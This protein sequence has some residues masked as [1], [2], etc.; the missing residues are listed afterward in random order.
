MG[1]KSPNLFGLVPPMCSW[2]PI[3]VFW[4]DKRDSSEIRKSAISLQQND[5]ETC[6]I[7]LWTAFCMTLKVAASK[8]KI[9]KFFMIKCSRTCWSYER[10]KVALPPPEN[11]GTKRFWKSLIIGKTIRKIWSGMFFCFEKNP[12]SVFFF[13]IRSSFINKNGLKSKK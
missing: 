9:S 7:W 13:R 12:L 10:A 11:I 2:R 3:E 5:L 4:P 6:K 8:K 1:P